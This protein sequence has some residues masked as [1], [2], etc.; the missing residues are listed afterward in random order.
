MST[1]KKQRFLLPENNW[2]EMLRC[3]KFGLVNDNVDA[4]EVMAVNFLNQ[5]IPVAGNSAW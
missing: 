4:K 2:R 3:F 5:H 1:K